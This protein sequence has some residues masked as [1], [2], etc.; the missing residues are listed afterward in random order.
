MII[1]HCANLFVIK[2][3]IC[4]IKDWQL[5]F[6]TFNEDVNYTLNFYVSRYNAIFKIYNKA[7]GSNCFQNTVM[8][9]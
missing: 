1:K 4:A 9:F 3:P 7:K 5:K 8:K 6:L 2:G